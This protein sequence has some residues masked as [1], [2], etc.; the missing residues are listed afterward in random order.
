MSASTLLYY[1]R[2]GDGKAHIRLIQSPTTNAGSETDELHQHLDQS[3]V[4]TPGK[5][6]AASAARRAA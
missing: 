1:H 6:K 5:G 3:E 2:V 4:A